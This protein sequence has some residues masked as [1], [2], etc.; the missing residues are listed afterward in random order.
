MIRRSVRYIVGPHGT[1]SIQIA[2]VTSARATVRLGCPT[3][4]AQ[5]W[6]NVGRPLSKEFPTRNPACSTATEQCC[7][8]RSRQRYSRHLF[9]IYSWPSCRRISAA[10]D[11]VVGRPLASSV[12]VLS[13]LEHGP[14]NLWLRLVAFGTAGPTYSDFRNPPSIASSRVETMEG[15][16]AAAGP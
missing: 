9:Q 4:K 6:E 10:K 5:M 3:Q 12:Q 7:V 1:F 2:T 8:M 13:D 11:T 16:L 14:G 15:R